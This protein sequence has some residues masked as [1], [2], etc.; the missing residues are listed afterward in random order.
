LFVVWEINKPEL[1]FQ[2]FT[3]KNVISLQSTKITL[4]KV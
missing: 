4:D 2:T 1:H 3:F